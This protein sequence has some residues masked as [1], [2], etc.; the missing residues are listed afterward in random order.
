MA[1]KYIE[2]II[3]ELYLDSIYLKSINKV[4][5]L[6][7]TV[8][9][10]LVVSYGKMDSINLSSRFCKNYILRAVEHK[11]WSG[12]ISAGRGYDLEDKVSRKE[13]AE[14]S[15]T[16][17]QIDD[18]LTNT[19][20]DF[21]TTLKHIYN[22]NLLHL[23]GVEIEKPFTGFKHGYALHIYQDEYLGNYQELK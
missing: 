17:D 19:L 21:R 8:Q 2:Q 3:G 4:I 11:G 20:Q 15:L 18:I 10:E 13:A 23:V 1:Y 22:S 5:Y 6:N 9:F 16:E 7:D 12:S 14:H